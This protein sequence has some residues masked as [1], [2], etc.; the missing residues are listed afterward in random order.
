MSCFLVIGTRIKPEYEILQERL[1]VQED[2]SSLW[3]SIHVSLLFRRKI[4]Y[5]MANTFGQTFMLVI[6]G[7]LTLYFEPS[8]FTD[9]IMVTLTTMLVIATIM[10]S[11]NL[12]GNWHTKCIHIFQS[13][14]NRDPRH[15]SK[16]VNSY[17]PG[18]SNN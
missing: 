12:V 8:N 2:N 7:Y 5:H 13:T 4:E 1:L 17:R 14:F 9:R 15:K 11:I 10:S 3:A 18:R 6:I 16:K